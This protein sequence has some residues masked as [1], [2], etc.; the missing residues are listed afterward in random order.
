[1]SYQP[2]CKV[3]TRLSQPGWA[4][5]ERLAIHTLP[6][7]NISG[8]GTMDTSTRKTLC[9][10]P[11][12]LG[13]TSVVSDSKSGVKQSCYK[14]KKPL[15]FALL[16]RG[17]NFQCPGP[18]QVDNT[19]GLKYEYSD[20]WIVSVKHNS[21]DINWLNSHLNKQKVIQIWIHI[22]SS[23]MQFCHVEVIVA[24]HTSVN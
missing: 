10:A 2:S 22:I 23:N 4:Y 9:A 18:A 16:F 20:N 17:R 11:F 24:L 5:Y 8:S 15:S 21:P 13:L 6:F 1:M 19:V 12:F 7:V 14:L 3:E